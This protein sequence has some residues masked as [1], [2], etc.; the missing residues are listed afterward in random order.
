MQPEERPPKLLLVEDNDIDVELVRRIAK[1]YSLDVPIV[2]ASNGVEA[3]EMLQR[4]DECGLEQ[5]YIILLDNNMPMMNG[6]ELL[7]H[8]AEYGPALET[9]LYV[10]ST[11]DSQIDMDKFEK[12]KISGYLIKPLTKSVFA[13]IVETQNAA[14]AAKLISQTVA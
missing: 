12:Y 13:E 3:L 5:P 1:R 10:L 11:S 2:R 6:I 8:M 4:P 14:Y 7:E 9:P